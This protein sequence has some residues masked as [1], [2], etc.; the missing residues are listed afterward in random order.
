MKRL[1]DRDLH[2]FTHVD[3]DNRVAFVVLLGDQLIAVGRYDRYPD[4]DDAEVAFLVEDAHQG[5]GLG[6]VLLEHL[7]A[8][9]RERGIKQLRRRGA[10]PER[11]DGAGLPGRRLPGRALLRGRRRP[12]DVPDRADRGRARRRLRARA[13]QRVAVDR[14]AAHPV[15]GRRGRRQQRRGQD[16]QRAAAPPAGLRLRRAGL[17]GEPRR[18]ARPRR[19]R[20]RRR[21][22]H[23]GRRRPGGPRRA[24]RRGR[25]RGRGVPAQAGAR[26]G[27]GLRRLRRE[28]TGRPGRGAPVSSPRR[29]PRACGWSAPTASGS[30]T[31]TPRCGSTPASRR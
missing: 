16:R 2:R 9:A 6:S 15:V 12:P 18:P 24:G 3:H 21:R 27:R 5:R 14:P 7:A 4:T 10:R 19:A 11:Q 23:P 25:R 31:P 22:V 30:S 8:A 20:L 26:A 1:S 29:G 17:P 13:A 28:R